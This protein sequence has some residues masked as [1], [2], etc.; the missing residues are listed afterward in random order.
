MAGR[1]ARGREKKGGPPP[2]TP[3]GCGGA[4]GRLPDGGRGSGR[5]GGQECASWDTLLVDQHDVAGTQLEVSLRA[6]LH[7]LVVVEADPAGVGPLV[8][9]D[10]DA[11]TRREFGQAAGGN[12]DIGKGGAPSVIG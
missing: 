11:G 6:I 9:Q 7:R 8:P 3:P 5:D 4:A 10:H 1:A 12:Q 2:R